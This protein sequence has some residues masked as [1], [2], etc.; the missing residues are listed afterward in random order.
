MQKFIS[1]VNEHLS[2]EKDSPHRHDCHDPPHATCA[3]FHDHRSPPRRLAEVA[4]PAPW[5]TR[6]DRV[7]FPG[8]ARRSRRLLWIVG[9]DRRN[10]GRGEDYLLRYRNGKEC[11]PE[12]GIHTS[13]R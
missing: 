11:H 10:I 2:W 8:D 5:K 6:P 1:F 13:L 7:G 4:R 3:G 12:Q 9:S